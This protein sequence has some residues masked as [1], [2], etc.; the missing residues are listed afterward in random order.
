MKKLCT[1]LCGALLALGAAVSAKADDAVEVTRLTV[2]LKSGAQEHYDFPD[3]PEVSFPGDKM[4]VKSDV[5]ET[6][7]DRA[8]V[9]EF[10]FTKGLRGSAVDEV[11]ADAGYSF[12]YSSQTVTIAGAPSATVYAADG[13]CVASATAADGLVTISLAALPSGVYVVAPEGHAAVKIK[14]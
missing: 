11:G 7:Y 10:G 13:R 9:A 3:K 12:G 4:A 2:T 14:K 5:A 6:E 1:L 8:D